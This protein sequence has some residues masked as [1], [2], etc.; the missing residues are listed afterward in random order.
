MLSGAALWGVVLVAIT[1]V[2]SG[3]DALS[4]GSLTLAWLLVAAVG[5]FGLLR[6]PPSPAVPPLVRLADGTASRWLLGGLAL[7]A[8]G[9]LVTALVSAPNNWDSMTY[10]LTRV[11]HW[12]QNASVHFYPTQHV[13][14]TTTTRWRNG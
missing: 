3:V 8:A 12:V 5:G 6:L 10:H 9:T 13:A 7:V 2:S 14:R 1:E 4:A 11:E